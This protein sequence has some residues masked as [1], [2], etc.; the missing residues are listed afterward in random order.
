MAFIFW[1]SVI[2]VFYTYAGYPVLIWV[3][4]I[5]RFQLKAK[6]V[7]EWPEVTFI[8]P[9]YNDL[10]KA[11]R[12]IENL[13]EVDYPCDKV[14]I[15]M[16]SDGSNDGTAE[17][18]SKDNRINFIGYDVRQGKPT[19]LNLGV[20]HSESDI[21]VFTDV[22]QQ[23]KAD[24][25]KLL[26]AR[27]LE[28]G[29]GA[30][31]G[32]LVLLDPETHTGAHVSLYWQY[33]KFIRNA[34]SKVASVAG[35]TGALYAIR[36][37][38]Y[39]PLAA[40]TLLD[41]FDVPLEIIRA[42]KRCLIELGAIIYDFPQENTAAEKLRKIRTLTGNYQSFFR[43]SWV[44]SPV[45]NPIWIQFISHKFLRL[46]VPYFLISAFISSAFISGYLSFFAF[47]GQVIFYGLALTSN[48]VPKMK[49]NKVVSLTNVFTELN[50]AAV[51]ALKNYLTQGVNV[52]WDKTS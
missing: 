41:D 43:H 52:K 15:L 45:K 18:L 48:A 35:V 46:V 38:D 44:F 27:L 22:R 28:P 1:L 11:K 19:A 34:E 14:T 7:I 39:V 16:V 13:L 25:I 49:E 24:A 2:M 17:C 31:S 32:E 4:S 21:I 51:L 42:G 37:S 50:W 30:V 40:D 20:T 29:V 8:V 6:A 33:E 36:R 9:V 47:G 10:E 23:V 26:V 12:K 5:G 3:A